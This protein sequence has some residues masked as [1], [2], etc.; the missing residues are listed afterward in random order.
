MQKRILNA[1]SLCVHT[2]PLNLVPACLSSR[3]LCYFRRVGTYLLLCKY[4]QNGLR[5]YHRRNENVNRNESIQ[6]RSY[7]VCVCV[8]IKRWR[9]DA[10]S[11]QSCR[12]MCHSTQKPSSFQCK[13]LWWIVTLCNI[14]LF[15]RLF[16]FL[17]FIIFFV[18]FFAPGGTSIYVHLA[19]VFELST[20]E[21][22]IESQNWKILPAKSLFEFDRRTNNGN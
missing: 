4:R 5:N 6:N 21:I 17:F 3:A 1:S 10:I 22:L 18:F 2:I 13:F 8:C 12:F 7:F 11:Y 20:L 14:H 19:V 9:R 15:S 16:I